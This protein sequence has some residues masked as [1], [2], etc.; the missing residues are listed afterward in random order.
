MYDNLV[1]NNQMKK[2]FSIYTTICM[3]SLC[4]DKLASAV[5]NCNFKDNYLLYVIAI[6]VGTNLS[7]C[8]LCI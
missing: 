1:D 7:S 8:H 5:Y 3:Y 4:L 2:S 6:K